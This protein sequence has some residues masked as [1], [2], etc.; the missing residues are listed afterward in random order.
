M[1]HSRNTLLRAAAL[2]TCVATL[3]VLIGCSDGRMRTAPVKGTITYK[4]K[5]VPQGSIMFQPENNGPSA[6]ANIKDGSYS[7]KTYRNGDGAV[8]GKHKVTVISLEDQAGLLPETRANLPPPI[9]PLHYSF[10]DKSGL[11]ATVEDK[12]NTIDFHLK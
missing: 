3:L 1:N 5:P 10:P 8:L 9:V 11:T 2:A 12:S 7:L 6:T 4:G